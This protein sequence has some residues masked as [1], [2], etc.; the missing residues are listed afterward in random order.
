MYRVQIQNVNEQPLTIHDNQINGNKVSNGIVTREV[1]AIDTFSFDV[2]LENEGYADMKPFQTKISVFNTITKRYEFKGRVLDFEEKMDEEGN[3]SANFLCES[4]VAYLH[5]SKQR[6]LEF[7][8]SPLSLLTNIVNYHNTQVESY[9]HFKIGTVTVTDP[10]DYVYIYLSAEK[11]TWETLQDK[12]VDRL[13]GEISVR[14]EAD[15]LY[16]DYLVETGGISDVEIRLAKNLVSNT[17]KVDLTKIVS[18]LK[19]LGERIESEDD[20][21][22]D[23]SEARLTIESVNSG[24]DYIDRPDLIQLVGIRTGSKVWDDVTQVGNLLTKGRN[25]INNQKTIFQQMQVTALDLSLIGLEYDSFRLGYYH[26]LIN[27]I[28]AIDETIRIIGMKIYLDKPESNTLTIGDKFKTLADYNRESL[29]RDGAVN[30]LRDRVN[31]QSRRIGSLSTQLAAAN[32]TVGNIQASLQDVDIENLPVELQGI[33][34]QLL[35]L[36]NLLNDIDQAVDNIPVYLPASSTKDGL[37]TAELYM[38]LQSIQP[39]T[40]SIDGLLA[41]EDKQKLDKITVNQSIDLDQF[42]TDFLA[43][44]DQVNNL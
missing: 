7:R 20:D 9:K 24:K 4:L 25:W 22:T 32:E 6:H 18:R 2:G 10:N 3:L 19:P 12:L 17:K 23:A 11:S 21:A 30:R 38:K 37:L 13:G 31:A 5:D 28:M 39:A 43:L 33:S 35:S 14:E 44:K 34:S 27:P 16:I 15:G 26:R 1:N 8:G 29:E 40:E 42:M 41:K 36:Q